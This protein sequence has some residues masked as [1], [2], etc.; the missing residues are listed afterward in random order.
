MQR[1]KTVSSLHSP[2][3]DERVPATK[4]LTQKDALIEL[5]TRY[6][7][8]RGPATL[9]DFA[10]WSGLSVTDAKEGSTMLPSRFIHEIINGQ[11]YIF[12]P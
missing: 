2:L 7:T 12:E 3:L 10:T 6:Y 11:D 8:S 4:P 1:C 5:T 9:R